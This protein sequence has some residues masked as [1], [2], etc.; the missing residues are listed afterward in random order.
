MQPV[1]RDLIYKFNI[2]N[3]CFVDL[4]KTL[5]EAVSEKEQHIRL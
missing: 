5:E 4:E 1:S 2:I 3:S